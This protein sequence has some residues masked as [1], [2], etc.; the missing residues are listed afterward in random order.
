MEAIKTLFAIL[1]IS[2]TAFFF[3]FVAITWMAGRERRGEKAARQ[4][5]N[6][7]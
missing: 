1:G 4:I 5:G 3:I 2:F 6:W 7:R